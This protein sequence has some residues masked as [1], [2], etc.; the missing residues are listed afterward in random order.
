V[1]RK[2]SKVVH[3][4]GTAHIA[5]R[6][7]YEELYRSIPDAA[8][9][10]AE[11]VTDRK[12]L[13][14]AT[15]EQRDEVAESLGLDS[16]LVFEEL[17]ASEG[18]AQP[19]KPMP[20]RK[21]A[22]T[23]V[24]ADMDVSDLSPATLR[25]LRADMAASRERGGVLDKDGGAP[26]CSASDLKVF[27]EEILTKRN[28]Y[29]MAE[30]DRLHAKHDVF[31]VPWGAMHMPELEKAFLARGFRIERARLITLARYDTVAGHVLGGLAAFRMLGP[32]NRPYQLDA[33]P[34]RVGAH[35]RSY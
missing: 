25:C 30:F 18:K 2:D 31:V 9:V 7:F 21:T 35:P 33:S 22:P 11:G 26:Q 8:V 14:A 13:L 12:G 19:G 17:L 15:P 32:G 28:A 4:V 34:V 16:Q 23:V 24:R 3:L 10:L 5:E 6:S 29:L 27:W 1:L 20:P